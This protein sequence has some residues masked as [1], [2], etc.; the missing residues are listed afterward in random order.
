MLA[1]E[2]RTGRDDPVVGRGQI[3]DQDIEM[4][5]RGPGAGGA[6]LAW[7]DSR[8][9]CGGGSRVTQPGYHC[10]GVPPSSPA[11]NRA[12]AHGSAQSITTS[13]IQPITPSLLTRS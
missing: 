6:V 10:T 12:S 4:N 7:N 2:D 1:D 11:Q 13:R 3:A 5:L 9:P 8:C